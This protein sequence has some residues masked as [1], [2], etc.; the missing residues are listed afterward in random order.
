MFLGFSEEMQS[1]VLGEQLKSFLEEIINVQK[2]SITLTKDL[3]IKAKEIDKKTKS[4]IEGITDTL[5]EL[6]NTLSTASAQSTPAGLA[7]VSSTLNSSIASKI[8]NKVKEIDI[9]AFNT[10]I[11]SFKASGNANDDKKSSEELFNRLE[12]V[13]SNLN[14][15]LSKFVKTS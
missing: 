13:E 5:K 15:I 14:K 6:V 12:V 10:Q 2:E 7:T 9:D 1:A 8:N 3:F 11:N 4:S